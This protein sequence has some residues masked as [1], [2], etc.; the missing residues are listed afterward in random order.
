MVV[1]MFYNGLTQPVQSMTDAA[2]GGILMSKT[3]E[4][5][6]NLIEEMR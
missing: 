5:A 1:Q 3:G 6:Y 2:A 4:E